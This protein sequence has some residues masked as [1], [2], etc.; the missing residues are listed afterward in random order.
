MSTISIFIMFI[1]FVAIGCMLD[2]ALVSRPLFE[3]IYFW[4]V[5]FTTVGL[6]DITHPL[7]IAVE[8]AI[9]LL[10]YRVFGLAMLAGVIDSLIEYIEMRKQTVK[11]NMS[12]KSTKRTPSF[13]SDRNSFNKPR[14]PPPPRPKLHS[15]DHSTI[16]DIID[17]ESI[18]AT[19]PRD[20]ANR[21]SFHDIKTFDVRVH[22]PV[23]GDGEE[24]SYSEGSTGSKNDGD[25]D[26]DDYEGDKSR[27]SRGNYHESD[28]SKD[29]RY[30]R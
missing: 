19:L 26:Y 28:G 22:E 20:H 11:E 8:W 15:E 30:R 17:S 3:S 24:R 5:T 29:N 1:G 2:A 16:S 14:R 6:G 21:K 9:P 23:F 27:S 7:N 18:F 4:I 12:R 10:V 13:A 25:D